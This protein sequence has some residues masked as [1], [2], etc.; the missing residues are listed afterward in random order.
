MTKRYR[1]LFVD[2]EERVLRSLK[3]V[4]RRDYDVFVA[5]SGFDALE[6]L[7]QE[8]I[9]VLVSDQRMPNMTGNELLSLVRQRYPRVVRLLLTGYVDKEAIIDTINEGE[10]FRYIS[11]PWDIGD[12]QETIA[13][14]ARASEEQLTDTP[15]VVENHTVGEK[16]VAV[17]K[18]FPVQARHRSNA[19]KP[20]LSS[21]VDKKTALILMDKSQR[22]R[23][24]IRNISR[25]FGFD[26]YGASSYIQAVRILDIRPD[27]GVAI[28]GIA[29]DPH[30]TLE[31]L[32][33]FKQHR[34]DLTVIALADSTD[35]NVAIDLINKGQVFRYLQKPVEAGE[36]DR[37]VVSAIKR[38]Q[39][40]KKVEGLSERYQVGQWSGPASSSIQ[41]LKEFFRKSA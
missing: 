29:V 11:K 12:M 30:E 22:V 36:F 27:V 1:I 3:S 18:P 31:A 33:L 15:V 39:M 21:L 10:I 26:V 35:A 32:N 40:L 37:A 19:D 25:R 38:H 23:N 2:D 4:F 28:I 7:A 34:P 20:S 5:S 6:I 16:T 8:P 41:K 24:S 14:A 9:D 13:L 17:V